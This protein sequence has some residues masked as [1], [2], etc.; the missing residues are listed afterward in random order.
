[1]PVPY[2][3]CQ[4]SQKNVPGWP[5]GAA[6]KFACSAP[7][8]P[9]V[10]W[11]RSRVRTWHCLACHAVIGIPRIKRKMSMVVISRPVF[12]SKKRGGLA[13][14]GSGLIFLIPILAVILVKFKS[15]CVFSLFVASDILGDKNLVL[16]L[17]MASTAVF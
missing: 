13:V 8:Q 11:V 10:C 17:F 9:G 7:R 4:S 16:V 1:M 2:L 5:G 15:S 12:L 6:V 3:F 14:V